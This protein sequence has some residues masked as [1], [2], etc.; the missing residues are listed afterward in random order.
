MKR[1][2]L[3]AAFLPSSLGAGTHGRFVIQM[4]RGEKRVRRGEWAHFN[5][6]II[7]GHL[8]L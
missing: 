1:K 8:E 3:F 2:S 5:D 6:L 4:R 7:A